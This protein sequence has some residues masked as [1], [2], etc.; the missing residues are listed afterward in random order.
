VVGKIE[1]PFS[2]ERNHPN[3]S[4]EKEGFKNGILSEVTI[5]VFTLHE[6]TLS[7]ITPPMLKLWH[8]PNTR[9]SAP[10]RPK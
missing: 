6:Y 1:G 9:I 5:P 3:P 2:N 8:D 10:N 7:Y 4:F